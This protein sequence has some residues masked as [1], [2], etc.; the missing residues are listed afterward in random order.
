MLDAQVMSLKLCLPATV[1][2]NSLYYGVAW[3]RKYS[4][5]VGLWSIV[6]FYLTGFGDESTKSAD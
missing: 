3:V 1:R 4:T 6:E 5:V 2:H